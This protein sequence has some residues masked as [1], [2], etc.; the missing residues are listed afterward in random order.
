MR[1]M[2]Y[3]QEE[4]KVSKLSVSV[5]HSI[6]IARKTLRMNDVMANIMGGMNK[7]EARELLKK[8][9]LKEASE[10]DSD[11]KEVIQKIENEIRNHLSGTQRKVTKENMKKL[12]LHSTKIKPSWFEEAW[13]NLVKDKYMK[14]VSGKGVGKDYEEYKWEM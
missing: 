10:K 3:L 13:G 6:K 1:Y 2:E 11:K 5:Q 4:D 9:G 12:I 8:Y 7:K 14:K